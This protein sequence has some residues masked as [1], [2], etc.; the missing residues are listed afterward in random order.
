MIEG[1]ITEVLEHML[2][3]IELRS[4]N[5]VDA[6]AAHLDQTVRIP[7]HPARHE[8]AADTGQC[9][10]T[11]RDLCRCIMRTARTEVGYARGALNRYLR[12]ALRGQL[13]GTTCEPVAAKFLV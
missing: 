1:S 7:L 4:R 5:P 13:F 12:T 11:F 2:T 8:V 3:A 6:F 9:L 10:R